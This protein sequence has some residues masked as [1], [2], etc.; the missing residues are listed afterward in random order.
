LLTQVVYRK[1]NGGKQFVVVDAGMND[2]IRP[3][4]YSAYH[5]VRTVTEPT[6]DDGRAQVVVVVGP[7]CESA[8]FFAHD[9]SLPQTAAGELL[10]VMSAGAYG[11]AM[12]SNYNARP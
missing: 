7:V 6:G 5:D 11:F 9:R 10:A 4:L 1:E 2:L 12:A 3:S 8:D